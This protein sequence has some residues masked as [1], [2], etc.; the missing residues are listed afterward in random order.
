LDKR[1]LLAV[2][3]S[4]AVLFIYQEYFLP[5]IPQ[6]HTGR[7]AP[8]I[9]EFDKAKSKGKAGPMNRSVLA[10]GQKVMPAAAAARAGK[11][12]E[13]LFDGGEFSAVFS[14]IGGGGV[15]SLKLKKY[16]QTIEKDSPDVER[17]HIESID[18]LP[19]SVYFSGDVLNMSGR[20]YFAVEK[21]KG[22]EII[23][24]WSSEAGLSIIKRYKFK[25]DGY[26]FN[27]S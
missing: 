20:E 21:E 26:N 11:E 9:K 17:V 19:L 13:Y 25:Q 6:D 15:K 4:I 24:S 2:V 8:V 1:A 12:E 10:E 3:L 7:E 27:V 23:Y 18:I 22:D 5:P 14:N 16:K